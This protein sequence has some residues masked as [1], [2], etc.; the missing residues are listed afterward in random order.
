[1]AEVLK[2]VSRDSSGKREAKRLRRGG[3]IPAVLYGHG[4]ATVSLSLPS[5]AIAAAV[6]HGARVVELS[7]AVNEK[8]LIR[9]L[10]WDVYGIDVL[11]VDFARVSEHERVELEVKVEL[12]GQA[13]GIKEGG[14]VE[15]LIHELEID[16][17]ALSIPEKIEVNVRE[18]HLNGAIHA[19]EIKLPDGVKL[20]SDPELLVAHC[21]APA[22]EEELETSET[23]SVEPEVIGRKADDE[24]EGDE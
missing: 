9:E 4:E 20:L 7:G 10:Q 5:D 22:A 13:P 16:C 21:V 8:A 17:E 14:I 2:V 24:G 3:S 19:G 6:R 11:H 15:L 18:L 1:M 12:R 23:G